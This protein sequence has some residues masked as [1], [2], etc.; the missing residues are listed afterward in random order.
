[1][2]I[3]EGRGPERLKLDIIDVHCKV[4]QNYTS[5]TVSVPRFVSLYVFFNC[6]GYTGYQPTNSLTDILTKDM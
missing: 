2:M 4:N 3:R 1:M 5:S 6:S